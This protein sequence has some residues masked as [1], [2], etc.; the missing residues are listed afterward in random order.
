MKFNIK[1]DL[2]DR[3]HIDQDESL[4]ATITGFAFYG[5]QVQIMISW[6]HNGDIKEAWVI[7]SRLSKSEG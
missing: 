4:T 5:H 2:L 6:V 3:V 7:E 1:F